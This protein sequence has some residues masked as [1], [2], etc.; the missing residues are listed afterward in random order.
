MLISSFSIAYVRSSARV[1]KVMQQTHK[2]VW[3]G[4]GGGNYSHMPEINLVFET[5]QLCF[6]SWNQYI[7]QGRREDNS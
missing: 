2:E 3:G 4:G 5:K 1:P 7:L 6:G